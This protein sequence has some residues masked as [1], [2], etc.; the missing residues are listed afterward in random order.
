MAFNETLNNFNLHEKIATQYVSNFLH[1][2]YEKKHCKW[3]LHHNII[4]YQAI[5]SGNLTSQ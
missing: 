3:I 4:I 1:V 2:I 5:L